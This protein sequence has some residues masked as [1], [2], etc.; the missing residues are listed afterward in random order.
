VPLNSLLPG[1]SRN[2]FE[3]AVG[4][5]IADR[6]PQRSTRALVSA[7]GSYRGC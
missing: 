7:C 2:G 4:T 3:V 5:T 6:P 1:L